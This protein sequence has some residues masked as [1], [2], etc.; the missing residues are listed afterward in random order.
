MANASGTPLR[1]PPPA[2]GLPGAAELR[3]DGVCVSFGDFQ[4]LRDVDLTLGQGEI[5]GLIGPNGAGKTTLVNVLSGYQ[6]PTSGKVRLDGVEIGRWSPARRARAG[7]GRT[8]QA[9]RLFGSLDCRDNLLAA[10]LASGQ[11]P[12]AAEALVEDLLGFFGLSAW[13]E[14]PA[15]AL[16]YGHGRL[17]AVARALAA[18][19]RL[20]LLDEP[21]AGM[22][23]AEVAQFVELLRRVP[24]ERDCGVGIIEHD[25]SVIMSVC[26]RVLVLDHGVAIASGAPDEVRSDPA[27]RKA[28]LGTEAHADA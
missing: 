6:R 17:L 16:P 19:P 5:V 23:E 11:P 27:V 24:S 14:A 4:V 28:Y 8:F 2:A 20:L 22:N 3:A 13:T 26:E 25:M 21:A 12:R 9:G 18:R 1:V 7:V 10:A 15:D